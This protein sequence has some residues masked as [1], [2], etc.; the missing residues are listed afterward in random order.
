MKTE[1]VILKIHLLHNQKYLLYGS[2]V[3]FLMDNVFI[4]N[5]RGYLVPVVSCASERT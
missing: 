5:N 3:T 1:V 2:A 4:Y